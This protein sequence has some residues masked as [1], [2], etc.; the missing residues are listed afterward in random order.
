MNKIIN[1]WGIDKKQWYCELLPDNFSS[2]NKTNKQ[3]NKKRNKFLNFNRFIWETKLL[4]QMEKEKTKQE[5]QTIKEEKK[6][7]KLIKM[8]IETIIVK[9]S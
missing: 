6:I 7:K 4:N 9:I 8:M 5:K 2:G 3:T 1:L